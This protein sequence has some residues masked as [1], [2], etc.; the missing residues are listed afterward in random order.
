MITPTEEPPAGLPFAS[1][2]TPITELNFEGLNSDE[3]IEYVIHPGLHTDVT[4]SPSL[5]QPPSIASTKNGRSS[6]S[7][8]E[9]AGDSLSPS[10]SEIS[11]R[12]RPDYQQQG[13]RQN[14]RYG[15]VPDMNSFARSLYSCVPNQVQQLMPVIEQ[16]DATI[17]CVSHASSDQSS[18]VPYEQSYQVTSDGHGR[19]HCQYQITTLA[20]A[21]SRQQEQL[22]SNH[23][24][25]D[26]ITDAPFGLPE[27]VRVHD[28]ILGRETEDGSWVAIFRQ[29]HGVDAAWE[30]PTDW[31][32]A[33]YHR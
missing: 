25:K 17:N 14:G 1:A 23:S 24:P 10:T 9:A 28:A 21:L 3:H 26:L 19:Q 12:Q 13:Y 7:A 29:L 4:F 20:P 18:P 33:G 5:S 11:A 6:S 15:P 31:V 8:M 27:E 16:P 22:T 32:P 2:V 30:L